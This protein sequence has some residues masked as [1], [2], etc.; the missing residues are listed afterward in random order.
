MDY[1]GGVLISF[2]SSSS[3]SFLLKNE[4]GCIIFL[5]LGGLEAPRPSGASAP[6]CDGCLWPAVVAG[7]L[8][9]RGE[10]M[11]DG[12]AAEL[13]LDLCLVLGSDLGG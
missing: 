7:S 12:G 10:L 13:Q 8:G 11:V 3:F 4:G 1:V 5:G 2:P 6:G 9:R